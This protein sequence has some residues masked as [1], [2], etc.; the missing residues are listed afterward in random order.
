MRETQALHLENV[1]QKHIRYAEYEV[2]LPLMKVQRSTLKKLRVNDVF[3]LKL[4]LLECIMIEEGRICARLQLKACEGTYALTIIQTEQE[5][6]VSDKNPKR[7]MIKFSF[8]AYPMKH[9]TI[10]ESLN[11]DLFDTEKIALIVNEKKIAEGSLINVEN[12]IA[13]KV[14]RV[15]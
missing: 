12:E 6:I 15:L 1:M 10:G 2:A 7:K 8:G 13:V 11:M 5:T 3:L 14:N 9:L 4:N